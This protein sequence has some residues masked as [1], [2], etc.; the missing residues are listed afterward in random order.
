MPEKHSPRPGHVPAP[1]AHPEGIPR[2][3]R[4]RR[5][6]A[7]GAGRGPDGKFEIAYERVGGIVRVT[8]RAML[9][10]PWGHVVRPVP[11]AI[12]EKDAGDQGPGLMGIL[13]S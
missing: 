2:V 12:G 10:H 1:L 13:Q 4:P 8:G 6:L 9:R 7:A 5:G 3:T 11:V